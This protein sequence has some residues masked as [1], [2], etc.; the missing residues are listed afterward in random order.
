MHTECVVLAWST[1]RRESKP[2][3]AERLEEIAAAVLAAT[4]ARVRFALT[5]SIAD[6]HLV[7]QVYQEARL[8]AEIRPWTESAVVDAGG[9][10]AY[11]LIIGATSSRYVV[12][13]SRRTLA[14]AIEH[15]RK[16]KGCLV[17]TLRTY[18]EKGS[19]LSLAAQV[20]GVH[21]HTVQYRLCKLGELTQLSHHSPEDRLTLEL[22]L[23]IHDLCGPAPVEP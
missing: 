15:D 12:E 17:S 11:R 19:S 4:G 9:L 2:K 16:R 18:L 13:F 5:E 8:A 14:K 7:A 20:L 10:G 3:I 21:V 1:A 22:A 6:P 23:R